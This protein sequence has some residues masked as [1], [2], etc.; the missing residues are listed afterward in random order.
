MANVRIC[1]ISDRMALSSIVVFAEFR[2]ITEEDL[3][4]DEGH[5]T[6]SRTDDELTFELMPRGA[7]RGMMSYFLQMATLTPKMDD[8]VFLHIGFF[9]CRGVRSA[10]PEFERLME[11]T[12]YL[13]RVIITMQ[14]WMGKL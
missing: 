6:K 1:F 3:S 12:F 5:T 4:S 11:I 8:Q 13:A 2:V 9:L 14:L 7:V 10:K